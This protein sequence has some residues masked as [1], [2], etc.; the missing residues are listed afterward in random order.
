M[1]KFIAVTAIF[2]ITYVGIALIMPIDDEIRAYGV[3]SECWDEELKICKDE[4]KGDA[5]TFGVQQ[6]CA[7]KFP[8]EYRIYIKG[9][10]KN[11]N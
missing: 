7:A 9:L 4:Q 3:I 1:N 8:D 5:C 6:Y 2:V 11:D 10:E